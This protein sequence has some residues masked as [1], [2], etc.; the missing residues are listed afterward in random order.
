MIPALLLPWAAAIAVGQAPVPHRAR[1]AALLAA[2]RPE[3]LRWRATL[4]QSLTRLEHAPIEETLPGWRSLAA[5]GGDSARADL[6]LFL[7]R[8]GLPLPDADL[9]EGVD[10]RLERALGAWGEGRLAVAR[11]LLEAAPQEDPRVRS[12]LDWL[13]R[14]AP[15]HLG[16]ADDARAAAHAVLA[17]RGALP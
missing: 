1:V 8:H 10:A 9:G 16:P 4:F 12:N 14:R 15:A 17:A 5:A 7:R 11:L 2:P 13:A 6:L 3:E